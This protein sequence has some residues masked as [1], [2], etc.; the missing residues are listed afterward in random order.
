[1]AAPSITSLPEK[2]INT[3]LSKWNAS[4]LPIVYEISNDKYPTGATVTN[5]FTQ[6]LIYVNSNL[7]ATIK[8]LPDSDNKT[9]VDIRKYVQTVLSLTPS[10]TGENDTNASAEFYITGSEQYLD[11]SGVAQSNAI[12]GGGSGVVHYASLSALQFGSTN[13]GNMYDYVLDSSKLDLAQWMTFFER[14]QLVDNTSFLISIIVNDPS[15]DLEVIQYDL[16]GNQLTTDIE[17]ISNSDI[18]VYRLNL[19]TISFIAGV[20]YITVQALISVYGTAI[21]EIFTVDTDFACINLPIINA[22]TFTVDTTKAGSASTH[23]I[24]PTEAGGT[25][26]ANIDW[27]D[28][29]QDIG[30]TTYDNTAWDHTYASEGIYTIKIWGDFN[31]WRFNNTGDKL[32]IKDISQW[33]GLLLGNSNGY[34]Y[35]CNNLT[36]SALDVPDT[37][38]ITNF[39][40]AWLSCT[41]LTSFPLIDTSNGITFSNCWYNCNS[42]TSFP[43]IDTSSATSFSNC[44]R[45]CSALTSF[46]TLDTTTVTNFTHAWSSCTSLTSF[47]LINTS[48]GTN[49]ERAWLSCTSLTSFPALDFRAMTNGI[50]CFSGTNIGTTSYDAILVATETNNSNSG[51]NFHGGNALYTKA[52]SAAATARAALIADH[53]WVITDGGPTA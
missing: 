35:G 10:Y 53:T 9:R 22:F 5:Y 19:D 26:N 2:T 31:G 46:P 49:F 36:I 3:F 44:W 34:F 50:S 52:T 6:V 8:Q 33:G 27:G 41:S 12:T 30:I 45:F 43:L 14:G 13:G 42:L 38:A 24:V 25:Y 4:S 7:V 1:M 47:P 20:K 16:N 23:F 17:A 51:V 39:S 18:G 28:S 11:S 32:K 48:S 21:S 15:F 29:S 37:S 40:Q